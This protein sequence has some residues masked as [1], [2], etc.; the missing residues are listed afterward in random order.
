[1]T[2][3]MVIILVQNKVENLH[4]MITKNL[5]ELLNCSIVLKSHQIPYHYLLRLH[6]I[7]SVSYTVAKYLKPIKIMFTLNMPKYLILSTIQIRE[8][9]NFDSTSRTFHSFIVTVVEDE[10]NTP[11][12]GMPVNCKLRLQAYKRTQVYH[13]TL[14]SSCTVR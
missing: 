3:Y 1:M 10:F 8:L 7:I 6:R 11:V 14:Y 4:I 5:H 12:C 2:D 13:S 9:N